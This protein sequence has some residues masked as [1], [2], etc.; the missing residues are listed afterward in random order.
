MHKRQATLQRMARVHL[1]AMGTTV[2]DTIGHGTRQ[3]LAWLGLLSMPLLIPVA[4][5]GMATAVGL[6]SLLVAFSLCSGRYMPL[7]AW[8]ASQTL[9]ERL[10]TLLIK[11]ANRALHVLGHVGRP[12]WLSLSKRSFRLINGGMLALAGLSMAVPVPMI[13]FDN[14]LPAL[15]VVLITWGLRLRDGLM[16]CA[17]YLATACSVVSVGLLWWGGTALVSALWTWVSS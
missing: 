3:R 16:L 9:S 14:V 1:A 13:S 8:L 11:A 4:L 17:G 10:Q 6:L 7:P 12:R 15:A 5:P 2:G